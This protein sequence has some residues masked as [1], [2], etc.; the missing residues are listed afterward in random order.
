[1]KVLKKYKKLYILNVI[2]GGVNISVVG[3][4]DNMKDLNNA[5][6]RWVSV[7][8]IE[9][10]FYFN[11]LELNI[12]NLSKNPERYFT[13]SEMENIPLHLIRDSKLDILGI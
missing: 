4:F 13:K 2:I 10:E 1:M 6:D 5:K 8:E 9:F 7:D 11:E 3:V 12:D